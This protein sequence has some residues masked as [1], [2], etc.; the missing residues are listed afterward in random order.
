MVR[1]FSPKQAV[2]IALFSVFSLLLVTEITFA[3]EEESAPA[4]QAQP[5]AMPVKVIVA[6]PEKLEIWKDFSGRINAVDYI[7]IRPQVGGTI[8]EV[9]FKDGQ[10]VKKGDLLFVID[11]R[12]YEAAVR[13][14][15][16]SLQ[17]MKNQYVLA[18]KELERANELV[19]TDALS[20]RV[21][22]ER[23]STRQVALSQVDEAKA[24]LEE[25]QIS[26]D[27]ATITAPVSGYVSRAEVTL[28][29][30]VSPVTAPVL[31]SI[32]SD[33]GVYA[34]FEIDE[35]TYLQY[36][37]GTHGEIAVKAIVPSL[38]NKEYIGKIHAFDN[39]INPASGTIRARA[40]F[41]N[42]DKTL[43]PGMFV[44]VKM[45]SPTAEEK[46]LLPD[47]VIGTDQNRKY[48]TV[49]D[50]K[51]MVAHRPVELGEAT[52]G[53]RVILSGVTAGEKVIIDGLMLLRPGMPVAPQEAEA[54][55]PVEASVTQEQQKDQVS[56]APPT[57]EEDKVKVIQ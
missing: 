41:A 9:G 7:E 8:T 55:A 30:L 39:R 27:Y 13:R 10:Y 3:N 54:A 48:V 51:N 11:K 1:F 18:N 49:A 31:T 15:N 29:N 52:N 42:T 12:P 2:I 35:K 17:T 44:S 16:A 6:K 56:D 50:E 47:G 53:R 38:K 28:G 34:D 19:K 33:S 26:L 21:Y 25:A 14:A 4:E 5:Q 23:K 37:Q 36:V 43:I 46:I 22:D 32:V 57:V 45:G 24:A 40:F 20:K